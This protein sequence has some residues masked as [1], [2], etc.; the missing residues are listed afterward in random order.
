MPKEGL[1]LDLPFALAL[2]AALNSITNE[3]SE[4][5]LAIGELSIDWRLQPVVGAL[6]AA[7]KAAE[8]GK[9]LYCPETSG[10]RPHGWMPRGFSR[11]NP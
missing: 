1:H 4:G 10:P 3:D 9:D 5:A 2:L 7:L 6:P 8:L 11:Q